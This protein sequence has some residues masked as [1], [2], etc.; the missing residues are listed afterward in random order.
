M[1]F[2]PVPDI[3]LPNG[4]EIHA[5]SYYAEDGRHAVVLH[6]KL[7][8]SEEQRI[9]LTH[10]V[11]DLK[12]PPGFHI[13]FDPTFNTRL[14]HDY[15]QRAPAPGS[16]VLYK[17]PGWHKYGQVVAGKYAPFDWIPVI[18]DGESHICVVAPNLLSFP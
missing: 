11:A 14:P 17:T 1:A 16:R 3:K 8:H 5:N 9:T 2:L 12:L 4:G 10:I 13:C 6:L 7:P 15:G 18:F